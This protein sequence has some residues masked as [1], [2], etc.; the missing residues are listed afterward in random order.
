[1]TLQAPPSLVILVGMPCPKGR[2][3]LEAAIA[4]GRVHRA[5]TGLYGMNDGATERPMERGPDSTKSNQ[6]KGH[7]H[8][9]RT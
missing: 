8:R 5:R 1:M 7:T 2:D 3:H 6:D 4:T 9:E